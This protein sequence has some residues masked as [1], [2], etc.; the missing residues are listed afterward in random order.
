LD[1]LDFGRLFDN[2]PKEGNPNVHM[3]RSSFIQPGD[4]GLYLMI[5]NAL[6]DMWQSEFEDAVGDWRESPALTL[7]AERVDVD[8]DCNR[9]NGI[10]VV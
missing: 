3:W 5:L 8:Y 9:V 1:G 4:G 10:L 6:D 7:E 2:D